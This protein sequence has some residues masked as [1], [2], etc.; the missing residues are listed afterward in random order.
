MKGVLESIPEFFQILAGLAVASI[1]LI[2]VFQLTGVFR[3]SPE[4]NLSGDKE[5]ISSALAKYIESC[6]DQ[7]RDGLSPKSSVCKYVN[8]ES[9][10]AITEFDVTK[11][12]NCGT[13]PNNNCTSGDCS[14]CTSSRYSDNQDRVKWYIT[15]DINFTISYDGYERAVFIGRP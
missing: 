4:V 8:L 15:D 3:S 5:K 1:L 11:K 7:N 9:K 13:I 10:V 12:L 6:W 2:L 14:F